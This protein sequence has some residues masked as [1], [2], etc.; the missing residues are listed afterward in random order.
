MANLPSSTRM[1]YY[2]ILFL[3]SYS[4][5]TIADIVKPDDSVK[6][7]LV[8]R[9]QPNS[10]SKAITGLWPKYGDYRFLLDD[11]VP[12]YYKVQFDGMEGYVSKRHSHVTK[13]INEL[14]TTTPLKD[15]MTLHIH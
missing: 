5:L 3:F 13:A 11:S 12:Y 1:K 9:E 14:S 4:A 7:G 8:F 10:N 6:N 15:E 2:L